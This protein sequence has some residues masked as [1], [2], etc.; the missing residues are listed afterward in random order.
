M[1][2]RKVFSSKLDSSGRDDI[3]ALN[4]FQGWMERFRL[5]IGPEVKGGRFAVTLS[6][7]WEEEE[8]GG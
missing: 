7:D 4:E 2:V 3:T 6:M 1:E 5:A 8:A